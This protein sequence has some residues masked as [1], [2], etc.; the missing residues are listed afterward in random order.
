MYRKVPQKDRDARFRD[1]GDVAMSV[2][3]M[4][5]DIVDESMELAPS[6]DGFHIEPRCRVCRNEDIRKKVNDLLASGASYAMISRAIEDA[7]GSLDKRD[8]VTIDSVRNHTA[9]HF[10]VQ[11][12]ARATYREILE[13]R[14]TENGIDFIGG[15]VTAITPMAFFETMMVKG[16][17]TLVDE[18][19]NVSYRDGMTAALKLAKALRQA[20][21]EYD[22]AQMNVQLGR[23]INVA[24]EFIPQ[25]KWPE[26]QARLRGEPPPPSQTTTGCRVPHA[27]PIG[28]VSITDSD[29]QE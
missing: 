17:E 16:Y 11:H 15:V 24:R 1:G 6:I 26:V 5:G 3:E 23:I 18:H 14:A 10:P 27:S 13:R 21:G 28:M 12:V 8:R 22:I 9:R 2:A 20:E 25:E 29:E 19:T 7:N 4:V